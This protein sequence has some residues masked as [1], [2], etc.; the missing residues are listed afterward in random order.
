MS[1]WCHIA[2]HSSWHTKVTVHHFNGVICHPP[3]L[4]G[5]A[6]LLQTEAD[7]VLTLAKRET[8]GARR[9]EQHVEDACETREGAQV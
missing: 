4:G 6:P 8:A 2:L 1:P 5:R 9:S 7:K 3:N